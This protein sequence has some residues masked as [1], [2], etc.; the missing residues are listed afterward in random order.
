MQIPNFRVWHLPTQTMQFVAKIDYA[1][2]V[3]DTYGIT[4]PIYEI[5]FNDVD[6]MIGSGVKDKNGIEIFE[7]DII[8]IVGR[9]KAHVVKWDFIINC[10]HCADDEGIGLNLY[11]ACIESLE[12]IG[13]TFENPELLK[14]EN[15][16]TT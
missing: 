3:L 8:K 16:S 2:R 4:E 9:K 5:P 12:I 6:F 7:C 10:G 13:N 1:N 11:T 15:E 14:E